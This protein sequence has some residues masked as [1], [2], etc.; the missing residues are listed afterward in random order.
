MLVTS[1]G[2]T[3][4]VCDGSDVEHHRRVAMMLMPTEGSEGVPHNILVDGASTVL[5]ELN[6]E[7]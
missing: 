6:R 2:E 4:V 7:I 1:E 5:I 3:C